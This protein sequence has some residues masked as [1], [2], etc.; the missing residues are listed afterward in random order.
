MNPG[1]SGPMPWLIALLWATSVACLAL[2]VGWVNAQI[3][4]E[5]RSYMDPL[6]PL[7]QGIWPFIKIITNFVCVFLP[8]DFMEWTE[9]R[10]QRTG[11]S[12]LLTAEQ[13][14][15]LQILIAALLPPVVWISLAV[16]HK[17][18]PLAVIIAL[19]LG[20]MFPMCG[21]RIRVSGANS[22]S[23]AACRS[24]S[25]SSPCASRPG[26]ICPARWPRRWRKRHPDPC[27]TSSRSC[28]V[29]CVRV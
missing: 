6:P 8:Y 24:I 27:A 20:F 19:L 16:M 22:P 2:F 13:F 11:V 25:I 29:I 1:L 17:S 26:S 9:K 4:D 14:V 23:S 12:Y 28:C 7:L 3:E 5:D 15:A 10:L 21:C 18:F